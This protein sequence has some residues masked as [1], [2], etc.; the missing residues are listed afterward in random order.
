MPEY[1][2][3]SFQVDIRVFSPSFF[4]WPPEILTASAPNLANGRNGG[5]AEKSIPLHS[6]SDRRQTHSSRPKRPLIDE[7]DEKPRP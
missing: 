1:F 5:S 6:T 4:A 2:P 3:S 7:T